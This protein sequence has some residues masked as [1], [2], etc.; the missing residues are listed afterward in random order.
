MVIDPVNRN[1]IASGIALVANL[2]HQVC[3]ENLMS[4][5]GMMLPLDSTGAM[6]KRECVVVWGY[7]EGIKLGKGMD[8]YQ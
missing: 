8:R 6:I 3:M 4:G 2:K 5:Y 1:S 7:V